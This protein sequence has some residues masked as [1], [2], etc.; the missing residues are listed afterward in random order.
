MLKP[1]WWGLSLV[2][3]CFGV[4]LFLGPRVITKLNETMSRNLVAFDKPLMRAR[5]AFGLMLL[6]ASYLFFVLGLH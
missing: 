1:Y 3:L 6:V 2:S 4:L 5:Y